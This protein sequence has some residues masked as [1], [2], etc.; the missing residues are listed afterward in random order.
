[1]SKVSD[2]M[3][4]RGSSFVIFSLFFYWLFIAA[5]TARSYRDYHLLGMSNCRSS[6]FTAIC[7]ATSEVVH[8]FVDNIGFRSRETLNYIVGSGIWGPTQHF[9]LEIF[10]ETDF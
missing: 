7:W 5:L 8:H 3:S 2:D 6:N 9:I 4:E 10:K 1:M